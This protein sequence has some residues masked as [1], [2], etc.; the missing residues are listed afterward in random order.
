MSR[1]LCQLKKIQDDLLLKTADCLKMS[2]ENHAYIFEHTNNL[3]HFNS[4]LKHFNIELANPLTILQQE[5]AK[6]FFKQNDEKSMYKYF[7]Q[8]TMLEIIDRTNKK[9]MTEVSLMGAAMEVKNFKDKN[10]LPVCSNT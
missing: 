10:L 1:D 8:G 9:T 7:Q 2:H 5:E 6:N 4:I 3:D